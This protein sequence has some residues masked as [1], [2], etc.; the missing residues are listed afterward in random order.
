MGFLSLEGCLSQSVECPGSEGG[1]DQ[2]ANHGKDGA[3]E[4]LSL[5]HEAGR[6]CEPGLCLPGGDFATG[7]LVGR[8]LVEG[9]ELTLFN[10]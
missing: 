10:G 7:G 6:G 1:H 2:E 3:H 8:C 5:G 4:H 9:P